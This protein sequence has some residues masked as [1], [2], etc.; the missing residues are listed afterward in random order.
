MVPAPA[1][2][3]LRV[4]IVLFCCVFMV[5]IMFSEGSLAFCVVLLRGYG[6]YNVFGSGHR[7][8]R[9]GTLQYL[10]LAGRLAEVV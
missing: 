3:Y 6:F 1:E 9:G 5:F 8:A 4:V 10:V 2:N 7:E